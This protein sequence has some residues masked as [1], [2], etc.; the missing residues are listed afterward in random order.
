MSM[1]EGQRID[2]WLWQARFFKTRSLATGIVQKGQCRIT[3][4]GITRR[5]SKASSLVRPGDR[6]TFKQNARI[7]QLE[8][9]DLGTRRG[10]ASEAQALYRLI[11]EDGLSGPA[12]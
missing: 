9:L 5:I 11:D 10:P 4:G 3:A 2:I 8:I 12:A 1:A 7:V 6:L